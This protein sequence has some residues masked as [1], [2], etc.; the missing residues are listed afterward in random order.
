M[1]RPP[2]IPPNTGT[3][4]RKLRTTA[5][6]GMAFMVLLTFAIANIQSMIW[7]TSEWMVSTILPAVIVSET[8]DE[9]GAEDLPPLVRNPILDQAASMKAAHMAEHQYFA[10]FSPDGVSPWH[11]F[12][13]A[14]YPFVHAGENLAVYFTDSSEIVDAWMDS[15]TH[16]ANI[17]NG[18]YQEIGI[19]IAQGEYDGYETVYVVQLFGTPAVEGGTPDVATVPE[20]PVAAVADEETPPEVAGI[21]DDA[22]I[23]EAEPSMT[24]EGDTVGLSLEHV[25]ASRE[26]VPQPAVEG[27]YTATE[28]PSSWLALATKPRTVL[29]V[30]Y[31]ALALVVFAALALS[32][33]QDMRRRQ[34]KDIVYSLGLLAVMF[35][36]FELHVTVTGGILIA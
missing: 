19:G 13:Q 17:L 12:D 32:I 35:I 16:R 23:Q 10:H 24:M 11:W 20:V 26:G 9:R 27:T 15:P 30:T 5:V 21:A 31:M 1:K 7:V 8:N 33:S 25:S 3:Q 18:S 22:P 29:Q 28:E 36:L 14:E 6:V 34:T 4:P 2:T